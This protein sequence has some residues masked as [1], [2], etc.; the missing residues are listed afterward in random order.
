MIV[1]CETT[2]KS[3]NLTE[4]QSGSSDSGVVL[5]SAGRLKKPDVFMGFGGYP[6]VDYRIYQIRDVPVVGNPE[7][8]SIRPIKLIEGE[9]A[10]QTAMYPGGHIGKDRYVFIHLFE[11]PVGTYLIA[12]EERGL[13]GTS[14]FAGGTYVYSPSSP[15][16]GINN[17]FRFTVEPGK[18]NYVGELLTVCDE[19]GT[20]ACIEVR[21]ELARDL[22]FAGNKQKGISGLPVVHPEVERISKD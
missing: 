8:I 9:P 16:E 19:V 2:I 17:V 15:N 10:S 4:I 11:L 1:G 3:P 5:L 7:A 14:Y 18:L 21:D 6:F 22:E 12:A 20:Q 13:Q